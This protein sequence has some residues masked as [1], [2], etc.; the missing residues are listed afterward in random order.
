[1]KAA[2]ASAGVDVYAGTRMQQ[3]FLEAGLAAPR[4]D[5][6]ALIGGSPAVIE[7]LTA[8]EAETV[9]TLLPLL[10]TGGI[11]T[12][13]EVGIQTLAAR[14]RD[15]LVRLGSVVCCPLFVG[16]WAPPA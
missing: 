14:Y 11:A 7:E 6:Y 5:M 2:L 12:A 1:M 8:Y 9:R 4:I 16:A 10:L 15:E 3:I 13:E